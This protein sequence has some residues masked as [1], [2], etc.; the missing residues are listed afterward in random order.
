MPRLLHHISARY[1]P[2]GPDFAIRAPFLCRREASWA[3]NGKYE[4]CHHFSNSEIGPK[5]GS[6]GRVSMILGCPS[7]DLGPKRAIFGPGRPKI[8]AT[9]L[10]TVLIFALFCPL[11]FGEGAKQGVII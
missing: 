8:A 9:N 11:P 4:Y 2:W 10:V 3:K 5:T 7:L 1:P 6:V